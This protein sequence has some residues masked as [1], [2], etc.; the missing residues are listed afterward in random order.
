MNLAWAADCV[1]DNPE[2]GGA[3]VEAFIALRTIRFAIRGQ[4]SQAA[5]GERVVVCVL[6]YFVSWNVEAGGVGQVKDIEGE[7][8]VVLLLDLEFLDQRSI[9]AL[10]E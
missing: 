4:W 5:V 6:G 8:E 1:R 2:A 3:G 7:P 10:L 9:G